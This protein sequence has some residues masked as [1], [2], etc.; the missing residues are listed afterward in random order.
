MVRL[1]YDALRISA[2]LR[3]SDASAYQSQPVGPEEFCPG[4]PDALAWD[5]EGWEDYQ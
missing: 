4:A 3:K 2:E 5:A 1:A